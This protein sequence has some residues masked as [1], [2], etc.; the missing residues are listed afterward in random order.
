MNTIRDRGTSIGFSANL[1]VLFSS[2]W[3][4]S[5]G[6]CSRGP[7]GDEFEAHAG[8]RNP[9]VDTYTRIFL[10]SRMHNSHTNFTLLDLSRYNLWFAEQTFVC[11]RIVPDC[12][13]IC[14]DDDD[15]DGLY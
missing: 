5:P 4:P 14:Y 13:P 1:G 10:N 9:G 15:D 7:E 2:N 12:R 3:G 11:V 8:I 6:S